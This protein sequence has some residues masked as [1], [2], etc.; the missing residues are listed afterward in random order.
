M[1]KTPVQDRS[2]ERVTR[3]INAYGLLLDQIGFDKVT[4]TTVAKESGSAVG[5]V[6]Q[7]FRN[8][9][10]LTD[11]LS[12]K[13]TAELVAVTSANLQGF[14]ADAVKSKADVTLV[15]C[16]VA[17]HDA[18][19]HVYRN[20]AGACHVPLQAAQVAEQLVEVFLPYSTHGSDILYSYV[21]V[22]AVSSDACCKAAMA[23]SKHGSDILGLC[24]WSLQELGKDN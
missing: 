4:T 19:E 13:V 6:Y 17:L 20:M 2:R 15:D 11:A 18:T 5:S 12:D 21:L 22:A 1:A 7:F 10:E 23:D 8:K 16:L 14:I 9:Q 24:Q 3:M